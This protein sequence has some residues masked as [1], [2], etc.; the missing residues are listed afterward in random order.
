MGL[1][2]LLQALKATPLAVKAGP[3]VAGFILTASHGHRTHDW[4][5]WKVALF[6][7]LLSGL[8]LPLGAAMGI[9]MTPVKPE[10]TEDD[11]PTN[12][13]VEAEE[14]REAIVACCLAFG[15]GALLFAVTVELYGEAMRE[16]EHHGYRQGAVEIIVMCAAAMGGALLYT[17]LNRWLDAYLTREE[18]VDLDDIETLH[19]QPLLRQRTTSVMIPTHPNIV[20]RKTTQFGTLELNHSPSIRTSSYDR[21]M[22]SV[23]SNRARK[24]ASLTAVD[25]L[26]AS[27]PHGRACHDGEYGDSPGRK[28]HPTSK[29]TGST[30]LSATSF[31]EDEDE[32]IEE[33]HDPSQRTIKASSSKKKLKEDMHGE[34]KKSP[35][36]VGMATWL[37]VFIDGLPE[38]VLLGFLAAERHL[39]IALVVSL[40]LA[41]FPEAFSSAS[42][43]RQARKP[44][45]AIMGMWTSLFVIT[46]ALAAL[47]A[48]LFPPGDVSFHWKLIIATT[49]GVAGG[50]MLACIAAVMLPEAYQMQGDTIG[51]LAVA[52]FLVSV[53][54]KVFGGVANEY[55]D[56]IDKT[57][58]AGHVASL[59][60]QSVATHVGQ[61]L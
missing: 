57:A 36:L 3:F 56:D 12:E 21:R 6:F 46:A 17:R 14:C 24:L 45:W 51:L 34:G 39:S 31:P 11:E 61:T 59:L 15:A 41:N 40:F 5:P 32:D 54:V 1:A 26:T 19:L 13:E 4:E 18:D 49:E 53:L 38:G 16:L 22:S 29:D 55:D 44:V 25:A 37:G 10:E 2:S 58:E 9:W 20:R 7:A 43:L 30:P 28:Q 27:R 48:F 8:S 52:G 50:A 60:L 42:L 23:P 33:S 35:L 47:A